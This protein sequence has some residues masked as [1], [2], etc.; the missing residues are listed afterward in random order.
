M[1][2]PA[3]DGR[4]GP[5]SDWLRKHPGL[6]ANVYWLYAMDVDM[7]FHKYQVWNDCVGDRTVKLMM[8]VEVKT[9]GAV[10]DEKQRETLYFRHQILCTKQPR[11]STFLKR[12][13]SFWHFGIFVLVM[14]GGARP[15]GCD[16][17]D[18]MQFDTGGILTPRKITVDE[19][20]DLL[21]FDIRPDTFEPVN[22]RRH[23]KTQEVMQADWDGLFP[24][25]RP[26]I[27]RS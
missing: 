10:P 18:W 1:T 8:D 6:D 16:G 2:R 24:V 26:I 15:D 13:V 25:L 12:D 4:D 7:I 23:H 17:I 20:V 14:H 27:K 21:R 3:R 19:L 11:Y 5:F 9:F 22:L